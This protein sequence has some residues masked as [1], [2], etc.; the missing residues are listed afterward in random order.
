VSGSIH[1]EPTGVVDI[2]RHY[3]RDVVYGAN[4]GII[5]TCVRRAKAEGHLAASGDRINAA[6]VAP[7]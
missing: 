7:R 5:T 3:I 2:A 1:R 4:D 6:G